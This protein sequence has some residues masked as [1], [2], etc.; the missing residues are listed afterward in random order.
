MV[1]GAIWYGPLFG[2]VFMRAQGWDKRS[3]EE[4]ENLMR[5]MALRYA[6]QFVASV[7]TFYTLSLIV[8]GLG[9]PGV[10]GGLEVALVIWFGFVVMTKFGDSLWTGNRVLFWLGAGNLFLT[11]VAAGIIIG[12]WR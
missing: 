7:I 4:R 6:A 3:K 8:Y 10:A 9:I 12:A 5:G 2:K 11:Y 1:I